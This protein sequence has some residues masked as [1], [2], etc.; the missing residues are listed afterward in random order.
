M[1]TR[2]VRPGFYRE[3]GRSGGLRA[4]NLGAP[5]RNDLRVAPHFSVTT[6]HSIAQALEQ[7]CAQQTSHDSRSPDL[8]VKSGKPHGVA[9]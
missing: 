2:D 6:P 3:I 1:T 5:Y 4:L 9:Q 7:L 8:P